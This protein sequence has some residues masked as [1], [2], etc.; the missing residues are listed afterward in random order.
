[1]KYFTLLIPILFLIGCDE[2]KETSDEQDAVSTLDSLMLRVAQNQK[3]SG[4]VLVG[5]REKI[6]YKKA[7]GK[8]NRDWNIPMST[9][10]RFDI[11]S[12]NKSFIAVLVLLAEQDGK[13]KL[14][15][16]VTEYFGPG[17]AKEQFSKK[18]TFHHLLTHT[19]GLTDYNGVPSDLKFNNYQKFKRLNFTNTDYI[20][21]IGQLKPLCEPGTEFHYSNFG[22]HLLALMLEDAYGESFNQL[23]Q[24][25][26]CDPLN[27]KNTVSYISNTEVK[28]DLVTGYSYNAEKDVWNSNQFIDLSLGR[29]IFSNAD[30]LFAWAKALDHGT[31]LTENMKSKIR[32]NHLQHLNPKL[33][34]G[35]GLVIHDGIHDI[36]MGNLNVRAPYFIHGGKTEGYK[37]LMIN[38]SGSDLIL[39]LLTNSGDQIDEL[40]LAESIIQNLKI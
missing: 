13:W 19:S 29:R 7:W 3:F 24:R 27:L 18:I 36:A 21:Y 16:T 35:Y 17:V 26:I 25:K 40:R 14:E 30:D 15:D 9:E 1:M 23:L 38:I 37:S 4:V 11:A 12:L 8:S 31:L 32:R 28:K 5:D 2:V 34:Y 10:H 22:Y 39:I 20:N 6:I 33:S